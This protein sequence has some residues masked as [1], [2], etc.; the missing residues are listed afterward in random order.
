MSIWTFSDFI[1]YTVFNTKHLHVSI[2]DNT[3]VRASLYLSLLKRLRWGCEGHEYFQPR[4][5]N[6]KLKHQ[7]ANGA[8][9]GGSAVS[10]AAGRTGLREA[11][12]QA[13]T[14]RNTLISETNFFFQLHQMPIIHFRT[15]MFGDTF[16]HILRT[17]SSNKEMRK[18]S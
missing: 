9:A 4:Y 7:G 6:T 13:A 11:A 10:G 3:H 17:L 1:S 5:A 18:L 15:L 8:L 2:P 14:W 16:T 12:A